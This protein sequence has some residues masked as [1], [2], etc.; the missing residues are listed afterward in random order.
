MRIKILVDTYD[1]MRTK[2]INVGSLIMDHN[3]EEEVTI[4]YTFVIYKTSN[5]AKYFTC[6]LGI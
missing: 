6:E 1:I 2:K 3:R 4:A 5:Q